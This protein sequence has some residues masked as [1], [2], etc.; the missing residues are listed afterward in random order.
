MNM[1]EM[2]QAYLQP[3]ASKT[4]FPE[5]VAFGSLLDDARMDFSMDSLDYVDQ[6]LDSIRASDLPQFTTFIEKPENQ[7]FL[8]VLGFY[9]GTIIA[10]EGDQL[11]AWLD[12]ESMIEE[13]P[14]NAATYPR[15]FQT[16]ATCVFEKSGWFLPLSG[17][18]GRLFGPV[19]QQSMKSIA[20]TFLPAAAE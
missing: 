4:P 6:L 11:V 5:Q 20:S 9:V 19:P 8:L 14:E 12:Y 1:N 2:A 3:C 17:V 13:F 18:C 15:V 10:Q 16:A 7:N